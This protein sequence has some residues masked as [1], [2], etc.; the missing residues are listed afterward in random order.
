LR[1]GRGD[2]VAAAVLVAFAV[3]LVALGGVGV[4]PV[5]P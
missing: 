1:L 2:A 5:T 4:L 3:A